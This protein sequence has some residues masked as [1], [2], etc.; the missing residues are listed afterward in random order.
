M[1]LIKENM[2]AEESVSNSGIIIKRDVENIEKAQ[3]GVIVTMGK[4][5]EEQIFKVGDKVIYK[6]WGGNEYV[7]NKV[8]YLFVSPEDILGVI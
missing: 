5:D 1:V 8:N 3:E 4:M 2:E 6:K 7:E